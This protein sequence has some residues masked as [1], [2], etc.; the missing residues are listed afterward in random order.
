MSQALK[1]WVNHQRAQATPERQPLGPE[2]RRSLVMLRKEA[3]ETKS[4]LKAGRFGRLNPSLILSVLRR[5]KYRCSVH[6]DNGSGTYGGLTLHASGAIS[7][8]SWLA[9]AGRHMTI[10]NLV[11][12]CVQAHDDLHAR[13][14]MNVTD[15]VQVIENVEQNAAENR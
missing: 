4:V 8:D 11:T 6:G 10:D 5:D 1:K 15:S 7:E 13:P 2:E 14:R 3:R 12:L 9:I